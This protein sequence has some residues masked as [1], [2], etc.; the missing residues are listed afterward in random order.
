MAAG[1]I[2]D[3]LAVLPQ[4]QRTSNPSI[5]GDFRGC[6]PSMKKKKALGEQRVRQVCK[7]ALGGVATLTPSTQTYMCCS[8]T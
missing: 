3:A 5:S 1:S 7:Q 8:S 2:S 4:A 6:M